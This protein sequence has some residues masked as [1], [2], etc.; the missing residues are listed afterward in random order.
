MVERECMRE[1]AKAREGHFR[2]HTKERECCFEKGRELVS[3]GKST[4]L[5]TSGLLILY[6]QIV[7]TNFAQIPKNSVK[8]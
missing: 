8:A 5:Y 1:R 6:K 3:S 4:R 7:I 2:K